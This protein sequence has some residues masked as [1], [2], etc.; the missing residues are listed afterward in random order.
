MQRMLTRV[1]ET[2]PDVRL[3]RIELNVLER[4]MKRM[5]MAA[6]VALPKCCDRFWKL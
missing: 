2:H 5:E 1:T 6:Q 3:K 4:E